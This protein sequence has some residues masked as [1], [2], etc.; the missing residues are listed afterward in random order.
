MIA[1]LNA[2]TLYEQMANMTGNTNL[3]QVLLEVAREEKTH[4]GKFQAT[5]LKENREL[6]KELASG[7]DEVDEMLEG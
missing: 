2:I 7:R 3:K 6:E 1:E 4:F 5:L